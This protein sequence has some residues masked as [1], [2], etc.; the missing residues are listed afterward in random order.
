MHKTDLKPATDHNLVRD[1]FERPLHDLRI[2]VI[3]RCNFRCRY[4][5]PQEEYNHRYTFL[6]EKDWL[7]F[8]EITR[9]V[10]LF[11]RLGVSKVRITGGEPLLR[12]QLPKLIR[13]ITQIPGID[14]L[15]LT[16]N[17]ALL[18]GQAEALKAAGLHRVTVSLD[19]LDNDIFTAMNG[20]K[21]SVA[22]I[23]KGIDAA[24]TAGLGPV[25][26]NV[27]IQ[28]G[29]NDH[30]VL[31][32]AEFFRGRGH[33]LRFIEYMDVGN[34]NHWDSKLVVPNSEI[35]RRIHAEYPLE[36][37][38]KNYFGEVAE[39]YRY[40]DGQGE[41]G[42]ISSVTQPFCGSCTRARL[43]TDGKFYTCLFSGDGTDLRAP[44]RD[45]KDDG[46]L[47]DLLKNVWTNRGDKYSE[48]RSL[49]RSLNQNR[50]K[51][52]MFQIGG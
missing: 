37:V 41:I 49:F 47:L 14:D 43:S 48:N 4:C 44:L 46:D 16:T 6:K 21:A 52:E 26:I 50:K 13:E 3:D 20:G 15:A 31:K 39:R 24:R 9:L 7:Q 29:A 8:D 11:V 10:R 51:I 42:F 1:I 12:P 33:V 45:G 19:A 35:L 27:V 23:L 18:S 40:A 36:S 17:G 34:C 28:K 2:S 25:K 32:L 30:H 38:D 5:M 22:E